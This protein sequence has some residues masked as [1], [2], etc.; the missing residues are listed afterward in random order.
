MTDKHSAANCQWA[1]PTLLLQ[2]PLWLEASDRP[3]SCVRDAAPSILDTTEICAACPRWEPHAQSPGS[4]RQAIPDTGWR[5]NVMQRAMLML[6]GFLAAMM[7]SG[8]A[9]AQEKAEKGMKVFSDSKCALCHSIA[10]KGNPK[11][12]LDEIGSKLSAD[13]I[14]AWLAD[15]V[16][17]A[18]KATATRK[19]PMKSFATMPAA[20]VEALVAY[21]RT[22]KKK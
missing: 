19:P 1:T 12:S 11:G 14:K 4:W 18:A 9:S 22:L 7:W 6:A 10:G 5:K 2:P 8:T 16:K 15:P 21:L 20:D 17:A 3:W 13:E